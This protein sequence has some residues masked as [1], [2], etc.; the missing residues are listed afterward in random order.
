MEISDK[1]HSF[2]LLISSVIGL[3]FSFACRFSPKPVS[4]FP[5]Y[6]AIN[7][8][9]YYKFCDMGSGTMPGA[10][11]V[12]FRIMEVAVNFS[13]M[14]DSVF[15]SPPASSPGYP[16]YYYFTYGALVHG[17][18]F[19]RHLIGTRKG[20]SLIYILPS[21]TLFRSFFHLP[22]PFFLH[23][24]ENVKVHVRVA[25]IMDSLQY[26]AA[27]N[28]IR[29]YRKDMDM[30]E[31]LNL[32]HYAETHH[33]PDSTRKGGIYFLPLEAG[34]GD[35]LKDG[36]L[37]SIAYKGYF[38]NGRIFDSVSP[39]SPLQFRLGDKDQTVAGLEIAIKM[40][41]EGGK[42]KIIIPSQL[43]FGEKGSLT[44][45]VPPYSTLVYEVKIVSVK[46]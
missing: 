35:S 24:G 43:A 13:K 23:K 33:L 46:K 19:E 26:R 29:Q 1:P 7:D 6:S 14:N 15:W 34:K 3:F 12:K 28:A 45:I 40:M 20:D 32:L 10:D 37:V 11:S 36:N 5:G 30:Q 39:E 9:T 22:L 8:V 27:L 21:D 17:T 18:A 31:Q 42:A 2:L 4:T 44:G 25:A 41:R 16:F 38:I